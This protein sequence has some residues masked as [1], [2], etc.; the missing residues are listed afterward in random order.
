MIYRE[1]DISEAAFYLVSEDTAKE[2]IDFRIDIKKKPLTQRGFVRMLKEATKCATLGITAEEAIELCIDAGWRGVTY[3]YVKA[4][5]ARRGKA[6]QDNM[7]TFDRL[8]DRSWADGLTGG[9]KQ[10]Q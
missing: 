8:T 6:V 1:I 2:Y 9:V 4:D 3:E 5:L 7:S 10:I